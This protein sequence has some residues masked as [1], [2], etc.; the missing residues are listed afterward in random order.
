MPEGLHGMGRAKEKGGPAEAHLG[1]GRM[2]YGQSQD[3]EGQA[4]CG[5]HGAVGHSGVEP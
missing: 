4:A 2:G 5:A 3:L 1:K